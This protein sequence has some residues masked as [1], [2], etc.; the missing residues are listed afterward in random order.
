ME[1][2]E[3]KLSDKIKQFKNLERHSKQFQQISFPYFL[4]NGISQLA[5]TSYGTNLGK[6]LETKFRK[7]T[8]IAFSI[9]KCFTADFLQSSLKKVKT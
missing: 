3:Q 7:L 6:G 8:K 4:D 5:L 9:D 1:E 2:L